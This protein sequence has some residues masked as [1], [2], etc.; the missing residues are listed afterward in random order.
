[1]PRVLLVK[2]APDECSADKFARVGCAHLAGGALLNEIVVE[3]LL[4]AAR[5]AIP[6]L[7]PQQ[8]L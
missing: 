8:V 3:Q 6:K 2:A 1:M 4:S 5:Q 7:H